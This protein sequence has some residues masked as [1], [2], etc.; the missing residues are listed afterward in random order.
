MSLR[1]IRLFVVPF[2]VEHPAR[3]MSRRDIPTKCHI[4]PG[5]PPRAPDGHPLP[6]RFLHTGI[7][8]AGRTNKPLSRFCSPIRKVWFESQR[9][10]ASESTSDHDRITLSIAASR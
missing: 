9:F 5:I 1:D 10:A 6:P 3:R 2:D 4:D 7:Y 8:S